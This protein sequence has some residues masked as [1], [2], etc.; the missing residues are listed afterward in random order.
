MVLMRSETTTVTEV[1]LPLSKNA[2]KFD[3]IVEESNLEVE[4]PSKSP[5][6]SKQ[7]IIWH[8]VV[9]ITLVHVLSVVGMYHIR[10]TIK[11]PTI[12]WG[13]I[14]GGIG[15]F[16]VTGGAHRYYTHRSYKAKLP[17]QIILLACYAVSGQNS[18]PDWVRDHRVHHKF[19]ET[20]ADPHNANRGFFFSHVGWLMQ[21]KHPEVYRRGKVVD[22]SD[23]NNDP[24]VQFHTKYFILLKLL[25]CFYLPAALPVYA[26]NENWMDA[27]VAIGLVRYVFNLN[28]TWSVNSVAH[29]WGNKPYDK[30]IQPVQN[31]AVSLV[32]MGEGWHN[33]HH[34]FPW[35]YRAAEIGGYVFNL[36]TMF[37]DFFAWIG[38][39]YDRKAPSAQLVQ[40]VALNH[41]DGSWK[42]VSEKNVCDKTL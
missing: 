10:H 39:V 27:F 40:Q 7:E 4:Q 23:I 5:L 3:G 12:L 31:L 11:Y 14:V 34:V 19:S 9:L 37:L 24:L 1:N 32:A 6:N 36:T 22:M 25:L 30:R 18:I 16:G 41:G 8:N 21:R 13:F 35:D 17:L 2:K 42:E 20:D 15:G 28:F 29:I 33:Y 38:W 26:W